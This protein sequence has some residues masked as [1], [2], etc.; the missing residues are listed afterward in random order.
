[1]TARE[2]GAGPTRRSVIAAG[3]AGSALMAACPAV[4]VA[5]SASGVPA[6]HPTAVSPTADRSPGGWGDPANGF[7]E[8]QLPKPAALHH[9]FGRGVRERD[10]PERTGRLAGESRVPGAIGSRARFPGPACPWPSLDGGRLQ[11]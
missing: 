10:G 7:A 4:A 6:E 1:M 9:R 3:L 5:D 2:Y 11:P 8:A